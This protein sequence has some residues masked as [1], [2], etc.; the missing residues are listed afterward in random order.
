MAEMARINSAAKR[1]TTN[2]MEEP[3]TIVSRAAMVPTRS[4][5]ATATTRPTV[6]RAVIS[7][8][9]VITRT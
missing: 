9:V 7:S 5:P 6:V 8:P 1:A 4:M 2:C 3:T